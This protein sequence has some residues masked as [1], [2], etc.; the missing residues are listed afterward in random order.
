MILMHRFSMFLAIFLLA[1]ASSGESVRIRMVEG[2]P[3]LQAADGSSL[4]CREGS[5]VPVGA[6]LHTEA[7]GRV[8]LEWRWDGVQPGQTDVMLLG[9]NTTIKRLEDQDGQC[10][11]ELQEGL[12]RLTQRHPD[13][14]SEDVVVFQGSPLNC[15]AADVIVESRPRKDD[16]S[17]LSGGTIMSNGAQGKVV[18]LYGKRRGLQRPRDARNSTGGSSGWGCSPDEHGLD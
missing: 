3:T 18:W 12:V 5:L 7:K 15:K 17:P 16:A 13:R 2:A 11:F 1:A 14:N 9:F 6:V 8:C 10:V 4:P